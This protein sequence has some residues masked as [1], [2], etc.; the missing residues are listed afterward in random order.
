[1]KQNL[2][3]KLNTKDIF[4]NAFYK[5]MSTQT[6]LTLNS[7]KNFDSNRDSK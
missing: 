2:E 5:D 4:S 3:N 1:M 6:D 7:V